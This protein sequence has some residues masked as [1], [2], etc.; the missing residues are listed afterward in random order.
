MEK[1]SDEGFSIGASDPS[2]LVTSGN[3]GIGFT[4]PQHWI[5]IAY[6]CGRHLVLDCPPSWWARLWLRL[7][8]GF[9]WEK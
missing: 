9:H 5:V 4:A 6:P 8:F 1:I 7:L 2:R 3:L